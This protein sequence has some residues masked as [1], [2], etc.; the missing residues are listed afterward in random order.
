MIISPDPEAPVP[1]QGL[2]DEE[3]RAQEEGES[4]G[5]ED[6]EPGVE[7]GVEPE[8]ERPSVEEVLREPQR[9]QDLAEE[10]TP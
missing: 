6:V 1:G 10:E 4:T 8:D 2:D 9:E 7:P 5:L 3:S